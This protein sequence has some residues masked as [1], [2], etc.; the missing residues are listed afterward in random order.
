MVVGAGAS[1]GVGDGEL[2]L[3]G[4]LPGVAVSVGTGVGVLPVL[5]VRVGVGVV[6][7]VG[8]ARG[9]LEGVTACSMETRSASL[10]RMRDEAVGARAMSPRGL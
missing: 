8:S 4:A 3:V 2:V 7:P 6:V 9:V 10:E 5:G 1:V